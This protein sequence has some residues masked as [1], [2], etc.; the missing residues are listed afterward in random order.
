MPKYPV[1]FGRRDSLTANI[2]ASNQFL[3]APNFTYANLTQ[4]FANVGLNELDLAALSGTVDNSVASYGGNFRGF[5]KG[6]TVS[7]CALCR[8][9][10]HW[11]SQV[12]DCAEVHHQ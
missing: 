10:H 9:A 3:P 8:C 12:R 6:V 11:E 5:D 7:R 1:F 2:N 4:N